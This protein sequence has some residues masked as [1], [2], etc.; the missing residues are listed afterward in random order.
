MP[1]QEPPKTQLTW[2]QAAVVLGLAAMLMTSV[3]VL[4]LN[5]KDVGAILSAVG[6]IVLVIG[7]LF[8]YSLH[9]KVDRVVT[10]ANG[11]LTEQIEENKK[12]N[13]K[14][15]A[16]ALQIPPSVDTSGVPIP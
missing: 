3:T 1:Y 8:G 5:N 4:A 16:L 14:V 7:G 6:G 11:R 2:P 10:I 9:N 13:E 12:L 15:Q